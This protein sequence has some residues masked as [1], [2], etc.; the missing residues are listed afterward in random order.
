M[1]QP[2]AHPSAP[3]AAR[4]TLHYR[5]R[6]INHFGISTYF[7]YRYFCLREATC[8][9]IEVRHVPLI[10]FPFQCLLNTHLYTYISIT[11]RGPETPSSSSLS[12][13]Q[14]KETSVQ[15]TFTGV[16]AGAL[17]G[18]RD[19]TR[20]LPPCTDVLPSSIPLVS[21]CPTLSTLLLHASLRS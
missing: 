7:S 20:S 13:T 12:G 10:P 19:Q 3:S 15:Y 9:E 2:A 18:S 11:S 4:H 6:L 14:V 5:S 21:T 8:L 1:P 16:P 17:S